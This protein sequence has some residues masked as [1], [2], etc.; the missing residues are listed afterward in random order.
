MFIKDMQSI[1]KTFP[2]RKLQIQIALT[3]NEINFLICNVAHLYSS[4]RG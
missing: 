1:S 2:Q 4:F 3:V